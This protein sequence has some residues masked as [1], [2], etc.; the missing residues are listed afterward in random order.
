M[1]YHIHSETSTQKE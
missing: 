1:D